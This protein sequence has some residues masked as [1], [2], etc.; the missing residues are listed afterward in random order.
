MG[1]NLF[2]KH[3]KLNLMFRKRFQHNILM[4]FKLLKIIIT[5]PD[6]RFCQLISILNLDSRFNE[7]SEVTY[8]NLKK[9]KL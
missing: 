8:N 1:T 4:L 3:S 2:K 5:Y 6:L 9:K 7:E